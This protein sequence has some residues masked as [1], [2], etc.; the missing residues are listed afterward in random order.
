MEKQMTEQSKQAAAD[1]VRSVE[2]AAKK[3]KEAHKEEL[4]K[5]VSDALTKLAAEHVASQDALVDKANAEVERMEVK[6]LN[7]SQNLLAMEQ[8]I[9]VLSKVE[10]KLQVVEAELKDNESKFAELQQRWENAMASKFMLKEK[11]ANFER[12]H[13]VIREQERNDITRRVSFDILIIPLFILL[14]D[15]LKYA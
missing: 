7:M 6:L 8:R 4:K 15:I 5:S 3:L 13:Q 14:N 11:L 12:D 1:K 9:T 2:E 10:K